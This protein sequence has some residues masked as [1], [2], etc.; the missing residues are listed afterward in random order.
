MRQG[1][2][3]FVSF[4]LVG[5]LILATI[6]ILIPLLTQQ[7]AAL[8]RAVPQLVSEIQ[9]YGRSGLRLLDDAGYLPGSPQDVLSEVREDLTNASSGSSSLRP[10]YSRTCER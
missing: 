2:A 9:D 8:V 3:I 6:L 1:L 7:F 4:I 10:T 5:G